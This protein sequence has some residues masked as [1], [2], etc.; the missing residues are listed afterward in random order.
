MKGTV[1]T[2][3]GQSTQV[4]CGD[5][6]YECAIRTHVEQVV[7][8]DCVEVELTPSP[9][10]TKIYPRKN[11]LERADRYKQ[12]KPFAANVD[13][14][15]IVMA[16]TPEPEAHLIDRYL[17]LA[18]LE[19]I[20]PVLVFNKI[21]LDN[22]DIAPLMALYENLGISV[23]TASAENKNIKDLVKAMTGKINILS[24]Q[25]GVGKS[26]LLNVLAGEDKAKIGEM[27][28]ANQKGKHTTSASYLYELDPNIR[29]IDSPGIRELYLWHR[30]P[31]DILK[32]FPEIQ[33][34]SFQCKFR[35]C[36]HD[37]EPHCAVKSAL[38]AGTIT[39]SRWR[40]YQR[41]LSD[42]K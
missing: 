16:L 8:G 32:G 37:K 15:V 31:G 13:Q 4:D 20:T 38:D 1:I 25:S 22:F 18:V 6:R 23:V 19:K 9:V 42:E 40:S 41:I 3:L 34:A 11:L 12:T 2:H 10:V 36:Q 33:N 26:S 27:S 21:D 30:T 24:G 29:V 35:N 17:V 14:L 39:Q 7:V 5:V 28:K